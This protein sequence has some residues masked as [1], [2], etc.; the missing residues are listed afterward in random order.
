MTGYELRLVVFSSFKVFA[1][2][3]CPL[4]MSLYPHILLKK[5]R[6]SVLKNNTFCF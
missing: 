1:Y 4:A 2:L 6:E 5:R 3:L